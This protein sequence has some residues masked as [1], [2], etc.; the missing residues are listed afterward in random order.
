MKKR[1]LAMMIAATMVIGL[2]AGC[3]SKSDSGSSDNKEG[4]LK[5]A[6]VVKKIW[7]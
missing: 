7:R 1:V 6:L 4:K 5:V 3:G 2:V